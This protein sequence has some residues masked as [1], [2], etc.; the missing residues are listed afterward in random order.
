MAGNKDLSSI[1]QITNSVFLSGIFPLDENYEL[2]KQLGIEYILCCVDRNYIAEIHD[3]VMIDNPNL[4]ILYL[5]YNDDV[6]QNLWTTNKNNIKIIKYTSSTDDYNK[7]VNQLNIYNNK[8]MIEIG[9]HFIT[10]AINS[11]KT[12]LV[13]CMAGISRSVS[14]VTYYLMKQF[15]MNYETATELVRSKRSIANPNDSFKNQLK[16]YQ[17][18]R[19]KFTEL[20]AK[21]IITDIKKMIT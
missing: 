5:P 18:R 3:K 7:L 2:V 4:T 21:N 13:H 17:L 19:D 9:Y 14:I 15:H 8:P 11:G 10:Q 1:S 20:D 6:E 16:N 12:I